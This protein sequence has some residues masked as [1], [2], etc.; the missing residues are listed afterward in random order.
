MALSEGEDADG[1]NDRRLLLG[2]FSSFLSLSVHEKS[3]EKK[4]L[5][6]HVHHFQ[7]RQSDGIETNLCLSLFSSLP[8][9]LYFIL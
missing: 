6:I 2:F 5:A 8:L 4:A 9:L 1:E 7:M 3:G